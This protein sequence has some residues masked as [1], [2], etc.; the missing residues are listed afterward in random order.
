MV[1]ITPFIVLVLIAVIVVIGARWARLPYTVALVVLGFGIGL[2][3]AAPGVAP[4]HGSAQALLAHGL[5]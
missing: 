1:D 3:G 4:L 2:F 5:F